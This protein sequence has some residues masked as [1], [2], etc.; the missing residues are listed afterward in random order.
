MPASESSLQQTLTNDKDET[1]VHDL[2][3]GQAQNND[4]SGSSSVLT[5]AESPSPA[6]RPV[7]AMQEEKTPSSTAQPTPDDD[8]DIVF[9]D[10]PDDP[11]NPMN[12]PNKLKIFNVGLVSTWTFITPLASSM[13][14]PGTLEI[15]T[16]FKTTN[17]TLG[18]FIVSIYLAGYAVGPLFIAPI[19]ELYGRLPT[20][21]ANNVLF[22]VWSL[23]CA[24]APNLGSLLA[25]RFFQGMAGVTP[26]TIGSGT[27]AD[28]IPN[29]SRGKYMSLYSVGPLLGPVSS[30]FLMIDEMS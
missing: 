4:D 6:D 15:L 19:S 8:P 1:Q 14:A 28:M 18:S 25:F 17:L 13:V 23:A 3:K 7:S 30:L 11:E 24:F 5:P 9:W 16:D 20:Y 26:L 27:I 12:W 2:E 22:I 21:H 10:S 29:E